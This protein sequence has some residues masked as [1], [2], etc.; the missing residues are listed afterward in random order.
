MVH[1]SLDKITDHAFDQT[2]NRIALK[3]AQDGREAV[4]SC[5]PEGL[6][7][8]LTR[9]LEA[10][11][12]SG[13]RTGTLVDVSKIP[14]ERIAFMTPSVIDLRRPPKSDGSILLQVGETALEVMI[15]SARLDRLGQLLNRT[16]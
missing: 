10:A 13:E 6:A 12:M 7:R 11:R 16:S 4:L 9:L 8:L 15:D 2:T 3:V 5:S 14:G 1:I